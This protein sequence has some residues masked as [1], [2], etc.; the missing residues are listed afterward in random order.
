M[1]IPPPVTAAVFLDEAED[2]IDNNAIGIYWGGW[3]ATHTGIDPTQGQAEF[4]NLPANRHN[5][6]CNLTFADG[7]VE[8]WKWRGTAIGTANALPDSESPGSTTGPGIDFPCAQD[9]PDL[10]R[11]K[12]LVPILN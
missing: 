5:Y 7:H 4:W 12:M 1:I 11:L 8:Y 3:N 6:G 2:S 9:D 10:L